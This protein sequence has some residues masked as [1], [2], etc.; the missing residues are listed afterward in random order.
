MGFVWLIS[1][2][3]P[4]GLRITYWVPQS[5]KLPP[6]FPP[7]TGGSTGS[8]STGSSGSSG[9]DKDNELTIDKLK[10]NIEEEVRI[11]KEMAKLFNTSQVDLAKELEGIY[12]KGSETATQYKWE[13]TA[14]KFS[15]LAKK[16][17]SIITKDEE[18]KKYLESKREYIDQQEEIFKEE[19]EFRTSSKCI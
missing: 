18:E 2:T 15:D 6:I 19:K 8:G 17:T 11:A 13:E 7:E 16:Q 14:T 9:S 10:A 5:P 12:K 3:F 4:Y 1:R